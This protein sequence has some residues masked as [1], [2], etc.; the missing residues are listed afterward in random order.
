MHERMKEITGQQEICSLRGSIK[1][2]EGTLIIGKEKY[3]KDA[4]NRCKYN[5]FHDDTQ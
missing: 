4:A 2:K 3:F 5:E 1:S